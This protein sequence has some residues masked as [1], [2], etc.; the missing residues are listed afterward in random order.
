MT[1][2]DKA[3]ELRIKFGDY[4]VSVVY[5]IINAR[6][7]GNTGVILDEEYWKEVE[8]ELIK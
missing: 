7:V 1:P 4:A 5:E 8:Q 2:K 3:I 6:T